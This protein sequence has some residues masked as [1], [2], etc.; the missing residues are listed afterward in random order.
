MQQRWNQR[1]LDLL[2]DSRAPK[3]NVQVSF[4]SIHLIY[5]FDLGFMTQRSKIK[6]RV[7]LGDSFQNNSSV[8]FGLLKIDPYFLG[9]LYLFS[10]LGKGFH[11]LPGEIMQ[12]WGEL[13]N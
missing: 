5:L 3:F 13:G 8:S 11:A 6:E 4:G 2:E 12:F 10:F 9:M 1:L 7:T